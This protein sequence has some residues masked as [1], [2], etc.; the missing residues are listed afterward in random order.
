MV[1]NILTKIENYTTLL[2]FVHLQISICSSFKDILALRL[3]QMAEIE[4]C[5]R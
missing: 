3:Y 2:I 4:D 5:F 1:E